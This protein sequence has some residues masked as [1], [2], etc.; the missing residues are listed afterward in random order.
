[1]SRVVAAAMPIVSLVFHRPASKERMS[2][3][4]GTCAVT[5]SIA[6]SIAARQG[7]ALHQRS[8]LARLA[9][10]VG[11]HLACRTSLAIVA[12]RR[13]AAASPLRRSS[14]AVT[15]STKRTSECSAART[16]KRRPERRPGRQRRANFVCALGRYADVPFLTSY[17]FIKLY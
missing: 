11:D 12:R 4:F 13:N 5:L 17:V 15:T 2:C 14:S 8:I 3:G 10:R 9:A 16:R 1:M 6:S 7:L